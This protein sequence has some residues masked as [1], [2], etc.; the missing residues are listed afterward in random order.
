K[1]LALGNAALMQQVGADTAE[2][3]AGVAD[4][5]AAGETVM[6]LAVDGRYAGFI[7]VADPIKPTTRQAIGE[8]KASGLHIVLVTGDNAATAAAVARQVGIDDVKAEVLP[9]DKYREVQALQ[10][11]GRIV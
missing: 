8:L 6:F 7:G 3:A 9:E 1:T 10:R 5:R 2:V 4:F 11:A